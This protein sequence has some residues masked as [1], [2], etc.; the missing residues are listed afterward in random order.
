MDHVVRGVYRFVTS[1][2]RRCDQRPLKA[3]SCKLLLILVILSFL[4]ANL[5]LALDGESKRVLLLNS[6]HK[7]YAWSDNIVSGVD[8][9][10][11]QHG[12]VD[13]HVEYMDTKQHFSQFY[14]EQLKGIYVE[15]YGR[16]RFDAII[17]SDDNAFNFLL[18]NRE[19]LFPGVPAVFCGINDFD[20][21]RIA[22]H[23]EITGVNEA[24][25]FKGTLEVSL[26][27]RPKTGRVILVS[28]QTT[29]GKIHLG[30]FLEATKYFNS[31]VEFEILDSCTMSELRDELETLDQSSIVILLSYAREPTGQT[32]GVW[33]STKLIVGHS[34]VPV[35]TCWDFLVINGILGGKVVSGFEQGRAAAEI[36]ERILGGTSAGDIPII[37]ESPNVYMFDYEAMSRFGIDESDLPS[38]S[39]ILNKPTS[40][41]SRYWLSLWIAA[42]FMLL[43]SVSIAWLLYS[44]RQRRSTRR[45]IEN[46]AEFLRAL[47]DTIPSPFFYKDLQ[48]KYLGCNRLFSQFILGREEKD[49]IGLTVRDLPEII[50]SE[51]AESYEERD[52]ELFEKKTLLTYESIAQCADGERREFIVSKA[53]FRDTSG[54]PGGIVGIMTDLSDL[55]SAESALRESEQRFRDISD[56]AME[57]I[58]E[59]NSGGIYTYSSPV[60]EKILGFSPDE[61]LGKHFSDFFLPED[62]E[63][64][65]KAA[66]RVFGRK[67]SFREFLNMNV[68]KSGERVLL[69]TSGVP[70]LDEAGELLG[71]RG[72]DIDVTERIRASESLRIQRDLGIEL[73]KTTSIRESL[74]RLLEAALKLE[75]IDAGGIYIANEAATGLKMV[76]HR[77]ISDDYVAAVLNIGSGDDLA[78]L[79]RGGTAIFG[80]PM[81]V[82][83]DL[84]EAVR[85]EGF[86]SVGAVPI[87][88]EGRIF[89]LFCIGSHSLFGVPES[90]QDALETIAAHTGDVVARL[91][92]E[93]A[94]RQSED[95]YRCIFNM[96]TIGLVIYDLDGKIVSANPAACQMYGYSLEEITC[97][98]GKDVVH[99]DYWYLLEGGLA[100]SDGTN[101][102]ATK[103]SVDVRKDGTTFEVE[104]SGS[105]FYLDGRT[106]LLAVIKDITERKLAEQEKRKFET[107]LQQAQKLESLGVLAGGIAHDFNNLLT[108]ILGNADL[109]LAEISPVSP[110]RDSL[111]TIEKTS[112]RAAELCKQMLAY[113]GKGRFL[114]KFLNLSEVV[115]EMA[116]LL[117]VSVSKKALLRYNFAENLPSIKAD[118][119]QIR[120]VIMNLITNASEAIGKRSG[121]ISI[122]TGVVECDRDYLRSSFL[123]EELPEGLYVS[124]E[125]SDTG[126][127]MDA[128]TA[129]KIF[130]PFF[131][132]KF[133]G[134][135]LGLAAVL[136]IV[137]G[138]SGAIKVYS[139]SGKGTTFKVLFPAAAQAAEATTESTSEVANWRGEGVVLLAEDEESV[140]VTGKNMLQKA[141]FKVLAAA[142]GEEAIKIFREHSQ[143]IVCVLLDLTMP[144]KGGDEVFRELR[145]IRH[146]VRVIMMSGYNEQDVTNRFA[147]KDL[148]GFIQKPYRYVDLVTELRKTLG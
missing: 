110:A 44:G 60:V 45:L 126:C 87:H 115:E 28:D 76:C 107:R 89:G 5:S 94:L 122:T 92:V 40:F 26:R 141:G 90:S 132:T 108:A 51:L 101:K 145:R 37:R 133:T 139:E 106:H 78:K 143:Q 111:E 34:D 68:H 47:I 10:F 65:K 128:E 137:R 109:A 91:K 61:I 138:H 97:L 120:Q 98:T 41:Y 127:G 17:V 125:V 129:N 54:N 124:L 38:G 134:R 142:N 57:W 25:D 123:D 27:L 82:A 14:L 31:T 9:V 48:G 135:G 83:P 15:K 29:T 131:T 79:A 146:D 73:G 42:I 4:P 84:I 116:H 19:D 69:S 70:I 53:L 119:T 18:A 113:S 130:D 21:S 93:E 12:H 95:K 3:P 50:P 77:A 103:E 85:K 35:F 118:P 63:E 102:F 56:N 99:P 7:G 80:S 24:P 49:F 43:Q 46:H 140:R 22:G 64:L 136:G 62:R 55:R 2:L 121:V 23:Y 1:I 86:Y 117:E 88:H 59:V 112:R 8:S 32:I 30:M 20:E 58:W 81:E 6:Y 66:Q 36:V 104:I 11:L 33:D 52:R 100:G 71:Y 144:R 67:E 39:V 75:G 147:G 114:I 105:S 13:L 148:A 96:V 74:E 72:A 16:S